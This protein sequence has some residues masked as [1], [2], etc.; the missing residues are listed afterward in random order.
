MAAAVGAIAGAGGGLAS[1]ALQY[2]LNR[3]LQQHAQAFSE[4]MSSTAHQRAVKD[5]RAAGLNPILS[6]LG[7]A[8]SPPGATASVAP[9]DLVGSAKAGARAA[10]EIQQIRAQTAQQQEQALLARQQTST[11]RTKQTLNDMNTALTNEQAN[12]TALGRELDT[13]QFAQNIISLRTQG[14]SSAASVAASNTAAQ[15][16]KS[17]IGQI[18]NLWSQGTR[19]LAG[20]ANIG[21]S[22]HRQYFKPW[23]V[24][25]K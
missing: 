10:A 13:Q 5:L 23:N 12:R 8:S 6:A 3:K 15:F 22:A 4:R 24:K 18:L 16:N 2:H 20:P 21:A 25:S 1:S 9:P 19:A 7:G 14:A 17:G 11:E